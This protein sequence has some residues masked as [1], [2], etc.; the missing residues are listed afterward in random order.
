MESE[1]IFEL[2]ERIYIEVQETK[3]EV[4][5]NTQRL[6]NLDNKVQKIEVKLEELDTK[7]NLSLEGH[8]ANSEQLTRIENEVSRHEEVIIRRV[9]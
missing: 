1:K 2:L 6:D 8:K 7:V 5:S 9:K 3:N 4:K